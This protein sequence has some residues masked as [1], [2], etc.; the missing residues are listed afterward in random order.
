MHI[1]ARG[2]LASGVAAFGAGAIALSPIQPLPDHVALAP[3]RA[4][5]TLAVELASA[6]DPITP[7]VNTFIAAGNNIEALADLAMQQPLPIISAIAQNQLTYFQEL[8][9]I[10]LI[11]SQILNNVQTFFTA[12]SAPD[13]NNISDAVV[14]TTTGFLQLPLDQRTVYSLLPVVLGKDL[15]EQL[16]PVI[17]FS[18]SPVSGELIGL[19]G[20][21]ISPLI[22]LNDSFAAIGNYI[23]SGDITGALNELINIPANMTNAALNGGKYL[24]LTGVVRALGLALPSE[25]TSIGLNMG[26]LLNVVPL[27]EQANPE[28]PYSGGVAFDALAADVSVNLGAKVNLNDPGWPVGTIGSMIGISQAIGNALV[29]TPPAPP[30]VASV[31]APQAGAAAVEQ[32]APDSMLDLAEAPSEAADTP[33]APPAVNRG[34]SGAGSANSG[35]QRAARASSRGMAKSA[36]ARSAG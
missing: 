1:T 3:Q 7:W 33:T 2:Y 6:I 14:A 16:Q 9:D 5:S 28:S 15:Y 25:V 35:S 32:T 13:G 4:V 19:L 10:G 11:A 31:A 8:P 27:D 24:D 12:P 26:G 34:R 30:A 23:Q 18:T 21:V 29:V 20:P 36:A 22:Q 17:D